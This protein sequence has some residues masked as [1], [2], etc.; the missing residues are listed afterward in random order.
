MHTALAAT[1]ALLATAFAMLT[2]ERFLARRRRHELMWTISLFMFALGSLGLWLGAAIGWSE[3][4]FK[5]FYLFGAI[6]N[7]PF[8]ALGTVYL[9][10]G[11]RRGD[12]AA[13][14]V[15]MLAA[16]AAGIVVASPVVALIDPDVLPR[17]ADVFGIGPRIAAGAGSGVAAIVIIGGALWSAAR[18]LSGRRRSAGPG[19]ATIPAIPAGRLAA[20]NVLIALGTLVLSAGG[21]LNSVV[22]EMDA[23]AIS[24]VV[25]IA[26]IFAGFLMTMAG[27]PT[28]RSDLAPV[29]GS[30]EPG[31][32]PRP[33]DLDPDRSGDEVRGATRR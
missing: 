23:F 4:T 27:G 19:A 31:P 10:A 13:A 29:R 9:L 11:R 32:L 1:A 8:L 7:V 14:G 6:L 16:F 25:G 21:L 15:T 3:W 26:V 22:N 5:L 30:L 20:A 24:L 18:L 33:A 12:V 28:R 2:L 17:G